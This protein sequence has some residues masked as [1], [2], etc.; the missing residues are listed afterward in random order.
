MSGLR[1]IGRG[2]RDGEDAATTVEYAL[3]ISLIGTA[4]IAAV[5]AMTTALR[6]PFQ[7]VTTALGS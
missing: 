1:S 4:C 3:L 6:S 5:S 2:L 7:T